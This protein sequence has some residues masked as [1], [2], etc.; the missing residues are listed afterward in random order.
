M[1]V[2]DSLACP[3]GPSSQA[4]NEPGAMAINLFVIGVKVHVF[5]VPNP[6]LIGDDWLT[7]LDNVQWL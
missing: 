1:L 4:T 3:S 2:C 7:F 6:G 5:A